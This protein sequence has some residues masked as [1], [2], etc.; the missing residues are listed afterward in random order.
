VTAYFAE[1]VPFLLVGAADLISNADRAHLPQLL[2]FGVRERSALVSVL[3]NPINSIH[4]VPW[5]PEKDRGSLNGW[6]PAYPGLALDCCTVKAAVR[7]IL[8][9]F[10]SDC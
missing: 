9:A 8:L 5:P 6:T 2:D 4:G 7:L 10:T 3:G 1:R